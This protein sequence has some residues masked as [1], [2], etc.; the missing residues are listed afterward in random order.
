MEPILHP[1]LGRP[2]SGPVVEISVQAPK[3]IRGARTDSRT[4]Y[5]LFVGNA[6]VCLECVQQHEPALFEMLDGWY[7]GS[8]GKKTAAPA[9]VRIEPTVGQF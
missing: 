1:L 8:G 7:G 4:P 2:V 3:V 6:A 9:L 5:E